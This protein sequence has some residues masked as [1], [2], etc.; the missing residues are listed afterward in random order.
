[1]NTHPTPDLARLTLDAHH[2]TVREQQAESE[3]SRR[4]LRA[5]LDALRTPPE[6]LGLEECPECGWWRDPVP[7]DARRSIDAFRTYLATARARCLCTTDR[8]SRCD[9]LYLP[10]CPTPLYYS[11]TE[12]RILRS[13]S[14]VVGIAHGARCRGR[15]ESATG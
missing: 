6:K 8:C 1:M 10:D 14:F 11:R 12:E 3:A 13:G 7:D 15:R 5:Q 4:A 9:E 2:A